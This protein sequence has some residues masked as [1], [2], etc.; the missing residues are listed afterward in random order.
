MAEDDLGGDIVSAAGGIGGALTGGL[1]AA[2]SAKKQRKFANKQAKMSR[3]WQKK[4]YKTRYQHTMVDM[5]KAGLNPI[6]AYKQGTGGGV[7]SGAMASSALGQEAQASAQG[8]SKGIEAAIAIATRRKIDQD[9]ATS[10]AQEANILKK[11]DQLSIN[12]PFAL[13]MEAIAEKGVEPLLDFIFEQFN[14]GKKQNDLNPEFIPRTSGREF[15]KKHGKK[16]ID[17]RSLMNPKPA[18]PVQWRQYK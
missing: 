1:I 10:A 15:N 12:E 18:P 3:S 6:L 7:P 9:T 5:K 11:T 14:T 13:I 2:N 8:A 4:M 17:S 16:R